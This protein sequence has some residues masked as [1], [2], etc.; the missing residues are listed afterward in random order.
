M[1][2]NNCGNN[3]ENEN[4]NSNNNVDNNNN[5]YYEKNFISNDDRVLIGH[6][7]NAIYN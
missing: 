1:F 7:I 6:N 3:D 5:K 2:G 4:E